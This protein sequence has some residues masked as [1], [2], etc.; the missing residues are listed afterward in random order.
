MIRRGHIHRIG[1]FGFERV[2]FQSGHTAFYFSIEVPVFAED[3][4]RH[5]SPTIG[6]DLTDENRLGGKLVEYPF[7]NDSGIPHEAVV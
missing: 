2:L 3:V 7:R 1:D 6:F 4:R 5:L